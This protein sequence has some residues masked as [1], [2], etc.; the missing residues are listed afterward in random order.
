[1]NDEPQ[2][3]PEDENPLDESAPI[4]ATPTPAPPG[5]VVPPEPVE[6]EAAQEPTTPQPPPQGARFFPPTWALL[7]LLLG[8]VIVAAVG[9]G[10]LGRLVKPWFMPQPEGDAGSLSVDKLSTFDSPPEIPADVQILQDN[11]T[12]LSPAFPNL[13]LIGEARYSVIPVPL[14]G[15]RWPVHAEE[16]DVATWVYGTVVNYV[17]GLPY[18]TTTE[19]RLASLDPGARITLTL[20]NGT[21]LVFGAPQARRYAAD[22]VEPL[23]QAKPGLTLVLLGGQEESADRLVVQA[24][25][26]PEASPTEGGPQ[27]V[28]DVEVQVLDTTIVGEAEEGRAFVVEYQVTATGADPVQTDLFDRVLEDGDGQRF[29]T[30]PAIS[31]Q[32]ENGPPPAQ[33]PAGETVQASAGYRIPHDTVPPLTWIFRADPAS[34]ETAR[35][36]LPYESPLPGPPQPQVELTDAFVDEARD[37]IVINGL[38]RNTGESTLTVAEDAVKLSSSAGE[39]ELIVATP[40]LPW[41]VAAGE[42]Q[43]IELQFVR[44]AAVDS[45]L[46]DVLGFTFQLDGLP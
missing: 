32:G 3:K 24:R 14:E 19:S 7:L 5:S 8:I 41:E 23:A 1:M 12:P 35:F 31:Q 4:E 36:S 28:A 2:I 33:I 15:G 45:V 10:V 26:L 44:P 38:V 42:E 20:N 39:G 46:L 18:T 22:N 21:N 27:T 13:L 16:N 29:S 6:S 30:N 25:Y 17:I 43:A 34:G 40:P 37:A 11:G 9:L